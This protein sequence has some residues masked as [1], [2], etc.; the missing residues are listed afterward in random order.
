M[1]RILNLSGFCQEE[2]IAGSP[3]T[4]SRWEHD[5]SAKA[6][7]KLEP[8]YTFDN[9]KPAYQLR[10]SLAIF[11]NAPL[12]D[13]TLWIEALKE[14]VE[15]DHV[16]LLEY[17]N[18][19]KGELFLL[20]TTPSVVPSS[21]VKCVKGRLQACTRSFAHVSFRRNF[22]LTSVGDANLETVQRYVAGQVAHHP[23]VSNSSQK[24]LESVQREFP[25]VDLHTPCNSAHGQ[26]ITAIHL[27]LVHSER[28]RTVDVEFLS[29]TRDA[30]IAT[31][32]KK[33][34]R[35]SSFR[36]LPDHLHAVLGIGYETSPGDVVLSYMN[37]IAFRHGMTRH[38]MDSFYVGTV[39]PYDMAAVRR[40]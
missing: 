10:W 7:N 24:L 9:C 13:R 33:G 14:S 37:N 5:W 27:V 31:A 32:A 38:W 17:Q 30:V 21:I 2:P 22:R 16:R 40:S 25:D 26:Y 11:P 12:P 15:R 36:I 18:S 1:E 8:L 20:S 3:P 29:V 35:I 6:M 34:H 23:L 28:W 4:L 39:G 19:R